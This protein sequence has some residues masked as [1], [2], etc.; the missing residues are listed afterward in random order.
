MAEAVQVHGASLCRQRSCAT[1]G[2]SPLPTSAAVC[3]IVGF[4]NRKKDMVAPDYEQ[5]G[6]GASTSTRPTVWSTRSSGS[7]LRA[8]TVSGRASA[9]R[10]RGRSQRASCGG[11]RLTGCCRDS[12]RPHA[13]RPGPPAA[14]AHHRQSGDP[15]RIPA[16]RRAQRPA[17]GRPLREPD[18]HHRAPGISRSWQQ[19]GRITA[20]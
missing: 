19:N 15:D 17:H 6:K 1:D 10:G 7:G 18:R 14:A 2:R 8:M 20:Q 4:D 12:D 9:E 16:A 3:R 5:I 11:G 13:P